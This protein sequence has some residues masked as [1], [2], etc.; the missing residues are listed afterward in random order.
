VSR[1]VSATADSG[2]ST[3]RLSTQD[4]QLAFDFR[5]A[6]FLDSH[7]FSGLARISSAAPA[8]MAAS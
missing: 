8:A 3:S 5:K 4:K 1:E 2:A 7:N 6:A